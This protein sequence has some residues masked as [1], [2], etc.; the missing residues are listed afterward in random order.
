MTLLTTVMGLVALAAFI[1]TIM[2]AVGK[3]PLWASNV[4]LCVFCL[5]LVLPLK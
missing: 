1:I 2:S 3:C 4:L 5:L